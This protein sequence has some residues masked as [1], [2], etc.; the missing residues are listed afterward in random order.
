MAAPVLISVYTRMNHL[1]S[2]VESLRM[3]DL[4]IETDLFIA[5]DAPFKPEH[6]EVIQQIRNYVLGIE[7]FKS[8][9]LF[10]LFTNLG[11]SESIR[12]ARM[13]IYQTYDAQIFMEDDNVVSPLFLRYMNDALALYKDKPA[14]FAV[15]GFNVNVPIPEYYLYDAYFM[16]FV[17]ANGWATWK[18]KYLAFLEHYQLPDFKSKGFKT[19]S[20][21]LEKPANNLKR[22]SKQ[23]VTWGDTKITHYMFDNQMVCILP[24]KSLVYNT[25]WD[26]TGE[27]CGKDESYSSLEINISNPVIRFPTDTHIDDGWLKT[28]RQFSKYPIF[29]KLKTTVYD[30]KVEWKKRRPYSRMA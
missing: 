26:G 15:C 21:H 22:M 12:K 4:A 20:K 9:N 3:N 24:C 6:Q 25:G 10:V 5:S 30:W 19:F 17:S 13:T 28:I 1:K 16:N 7:G 27:H 29:G 18:E 8:V 2:C 14:V 11:S 23:G